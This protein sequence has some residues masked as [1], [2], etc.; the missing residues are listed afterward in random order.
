MTPW[1]WCGVLSTASA[2]VKFDDTEAAFYI[3]LLDLLSTCAPNRLVYR[4]GMAKRESEEA[5]LLLQ[6][7]I[8][9]QGVQ[10]CRL[11]VA[12]KGF[13]RICNSL[14]LF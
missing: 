9:M 6:A 4:H 7:T 1:V 3:G 8:P 13:G 14:D 5:A 11:W 10:Q 12:H 2:D